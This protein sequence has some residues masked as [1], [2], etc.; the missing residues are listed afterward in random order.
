MILDILRADKR[1]EDKV[2]YRKEM[3]LGL[4]KILIDPGKK[5][6]INIMA[7]LTEIIVNHKIK[8][9]FKEETDQIINLDKIEMVDGN[10]IDS[11]ETMIAVN[12]D[13]IEANT[14]K[15]T[16]IVINVTVSLVSH[17]PAILQV[18]WHLLRLKK[19]KNID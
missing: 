18:K 2:D 11:T 17:N 1:E 19:T 5:L 14:N 4:K 7:I 10:Q 16:T 12:P 9:T 3:I 8:E 15:E 6:I 13:N